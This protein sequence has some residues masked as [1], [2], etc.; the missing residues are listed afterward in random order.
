M[1]YS[2][3]VIAS[4]LIG[5]GWAAAT[6]PAKVTV[7]TAAAQAAGAP[8]GV[9]TPLPITTEQVV[10]VRALSFLTSLVTAQVAVSGHEMHAV[11]VAEAMCGAFMRPDAEERKAA[12]AAFVPV[13]QTMFQWSLQQGQAYVEQSHQYCHTLAGNTHET[14]H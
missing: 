11:R 8:T 1:R 2:L 12:M 14:G 13:A 6:S 3:L 7:P 9:A 10:D 5:I 4:A